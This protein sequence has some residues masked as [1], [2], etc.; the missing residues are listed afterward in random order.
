M[1]SQPVQK[2]IISI[3]E[4]HE[5]EILSP[6]V[7]WDHPK[8]KK[9]HSISSYIHKWKNPMLPDATFEMR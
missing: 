2:K 5:K 4:D 6:K 7:W 9:N 1:G 3:L 8:I